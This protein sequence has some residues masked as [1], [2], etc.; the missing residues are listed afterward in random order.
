MSEEYPYQKQWERYRLYRVLWALMAALLFVPYLLLAIDI[1]FIPQKALIYIIAFGWIIFII[2]NLSI[3][4]WKCPRCRRTY[5]PWWSRI[6][7]LSYFRCRHC[8]LEKYEGSNF[9]RFRKRFGL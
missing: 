1:S 8:G 5:F 4:F 3:M 6:F 2:I 9:K 7:I